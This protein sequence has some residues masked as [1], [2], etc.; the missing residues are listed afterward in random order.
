V[1]EEKK[2]EKILQ[3]YCSFLPFA[4]YLNNQRINPTDP[5]W[6]KGSKECSEKEYLDFYAKLYPGEPSPLFWIHLDVDY[7]FTLK[8]IL[9]F[10]AIGRDFDPSR[11]SIKLFCNRVFVADNCK[12]I[13]PDYLLPLRGAIDSKDIPL[14]VSRSSLQLDKNVRQLAAHIS[15][16]VADRLNNLYVNERET[17]YRVWPDIQVVVKVGTMQ[18]EKFYDRVKE[19]LVWKD[20]DE[21]WVSATESATAAKEAGS[22][23]IFYTLEEQKSATFLQLF[24]KKNLPVLQAHPLIDPPLFA[25]LEKKMEG[26]HFQRVDGGLEETLLDKSK[27]KTLLDA[28]GKTEGGRLADFFRQR[29]GQEQLEVEAKSLASDTLPG[30][31]VIDEQ[32]RRFR[33][34]MARYQ[35]G[36]FAL[37]Q[38]Q[39]FVVNTN[40][41]LVK[42]AVAL[43]KKHPELAKEL[44]LEIYE[45]SLLAQHELE[46][47]KQPALI[48]RSLQLLEKMAQKLA[49]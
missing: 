7:P 23:K 27:E 16:K 46:A 22:E 48:E 15:K 44:A 47:A 37:P 18:D 31:V 21:K 3:H 32:A 20:I 34:Y 36:G 19:L 25:L 28:E 12:D 40:S 24:R 2:V 4:I 43:D 17:F 9:Y 29:L 1:L 11:S 13:I 33:D 14:N 45:L 49:Q 10:P 26:V 42:A 39:T 30:L 6:L 35:P 41:P 5:L 38:Q 8:G